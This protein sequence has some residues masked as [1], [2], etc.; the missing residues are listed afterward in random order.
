MRLELQSARLHL[1]RLRARGLRREHGAQRRECRGRLRQG[2]LASREAQ[3]RF[4][5]RWGARRRLRLEGDGVLAVGEG[6]AEAF[7]RDVGRR[8]VR[9][10]RRFGGDQIW[11]GSC[12]RDGTMERG[13]ET[14]LLLLSIGRL[15]RRIARA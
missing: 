6:G 9:E 12:V 1:R 10:V 4:G 13:M 5:G 14:D 15:R 7:E 2:E 8:A 3:E 11:L